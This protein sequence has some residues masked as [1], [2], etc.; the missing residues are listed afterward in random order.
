MEKVGC[1]QSS[2]R[3]KRGD[4]TRH[5]PFRRD[6]KKSPS[7]LGLAGVTWAALGARCP[8]WRPLA[9]AHGCPQAGPTRAVRRAGR[10]VA[11]GMGPR[12]QRA[13]EGWPGPAPSTLHLGAEAVTVRM[14]TGLSARRALPSSA[15]TC[16]LAWGAAQRRSLFEVGTPLGVFSLRSGLGQVWGLWN[17]AVKPP[18]LLPPTQAARARKRSPPCPQGPLPRGGSGCPVR[19]QLALPLPLPS[20]HLHRRSA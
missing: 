10:K 17:L 13:E 12:P 5:R 8:G 6:R 1:V 11:A 16:L 3:E 14:Q 4:A 15:N 18:S 2:K 9:R 19:A 7:G 20:G